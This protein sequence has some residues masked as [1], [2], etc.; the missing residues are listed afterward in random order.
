VAVHER[1]QQAADDV[2]A[3]RG[4]PAREDDADP[5]LGAAGVGQAAALRRAGRGPDQADGGLAPGFR[6]VG[7]DGIGFGAVGQGIGGR[8]VDDGEGA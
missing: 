2:V 3:A 7:F 6:E 1:V 8:G 5:E 4:L